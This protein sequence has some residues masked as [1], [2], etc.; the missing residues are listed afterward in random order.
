MKTEEGHLWFKQSPS[1][2]GLISLIL[3][4][5]VMICHRALIILY[6]VIFFYQ[7]CYS[8]SL[9]MILLALDR[10]NHQG[11]SVEILFEF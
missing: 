5:H 3:L 11:S 9:F 1:E 2:H 10:Y 4:I 7:H 6:Y 8:C